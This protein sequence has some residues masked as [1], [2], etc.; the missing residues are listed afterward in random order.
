MQKKRLITHLALAGVIT[1][2]A[3]TLA[4]CSKGIPAFVACGGV[5]KD[6]QPIN[7][8]KGTCGKLAGAKPEPLTCAKWQ[9]NGDAYV[10]QEAGTKLTIPH[11]PQSDYVRCYGVVAANMNDCGTAT[12]ACGGSVHVDRQADAWIAIPNGIC[13]QIKGSASQLNTTTNVKTK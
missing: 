10:C 1:L 5:S 13:K 2:S 7:M 11:Y 3:L 6:N 4:A 12:T 9:D 8:P